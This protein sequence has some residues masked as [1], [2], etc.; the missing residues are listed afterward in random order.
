MENNIRN[1]K[2]ILKKNP[3]CVKSYITI[4][5]FYLKNNQ[6]E[7]AQKCLN[8]LYMLTG[9]KKYLREIKEITTKNYFKLLGQFRQE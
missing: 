4:K 3:D 9:E 2:K 8:K 6:H 1:F 7:E 5:D